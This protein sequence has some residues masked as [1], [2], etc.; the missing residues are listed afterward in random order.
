MTLP[1]RRLS[2]KQRKA[3]YEHERDKAIEEGRGTFPVCN[4]CTLSIIGGQRWHESHNPYLPRALGGYVTG[5][6][7]ER[8]NL[9]HAHEHDV[10]LIAKQKRIREKHLDQRRTL[11]PL[12][13][14]RDDR[15]KRKVNG[16]TVIRASGEK[17]R[18]GL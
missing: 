6:A 9:R 18:P 12:P 4:I 13:G 1:R 17:W 14:G 16:K 7:H 10:P 8:C 5:I 15:L 2:P 11:Q 3:L